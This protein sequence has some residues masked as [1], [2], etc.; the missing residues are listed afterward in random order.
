MPSAFLR[1]PS[2]ELTGITPAAKIR[3]P[4]GKTLQEDVDQ[5]D[6][7]SNYQRSRL[8]GHGLVARPDGELQSPSFNRDITGQEGP[9]M[10]ADESMEG[11]STFPV[12]D[13]EREPEP[14]SE[15]E[16][17][18]SVHKMVWD[19]IEY[20]DQ[21]LSPLRALATKYY[22]GEPFGNEE[23]G[24]SQVV[25][26][27][28][29]DTVLMMMPSLMRIFFGADRALE[30]IPTNKAQ[31]E[32]TDQVTEFVWDVIVNQD[33]EGY[34]AFYEWFKDAL[35]KKLGILKVWYD[36]T[37]ETRAFEANFLSPESVAKLHAEKGVRID[38][39]ELSVANQ[40][41][42]P[43]Y[44]VE[45]TQ[46]KQ[47]GAI[48]F[49]ALPPEEYLFT[50]GSRT[51][52][53]AR[54]RP[55][56]ALFV[57]HRTEMTRSQ[58][59]E[60]GIDEETIE[61]WAFK[62]D[63]LDHNQEEIARQEIV[64]PDTNAIGP[65]ATQKSLYIE[66]YPYLDLDGD[67][68][69]ELCKVVM[70][71]P[72]YH[73][74]SAEPTSHRPFCVICPDPEPHTIVGQG[75]SDWTMDLQ[76]IQSMIL[77]SI[78]DSLALTINPR[79]GFVEGGASLEDI[80][81]PE[82]GAPIRMSMP[83]ALQPIEHSFVG[84]EGLAV[85]E[86]INELKELRSGTT[87]ASAGL[88]ADALQ[89]TTKAAASAAIT[90][91]QAHIEMIARTFAETGVK[92][93]FRMVLELLVSHPPRE[94]MVKMRGRY[95]EM[96][97]SRWDA[98]LDVKVKVAIGAGLDED[99][100]QAL[101]ET[102]EEMKSMFQMWG[103]SNPI[104]TP[105]QYRDINVRMLKLRG[106]MDAENFFQETD[107]N[108]QPPPPPQ[109]DPN[110]V[111][112]E[113]EKAKAET[114]AQAALHKAQMEE[115]KHQ[116]ILQDKIRE[117]ELKIQQTQVDAQLEREKVAIQ[118]QTQIAVAQINAQMEEQRQSLDETMRKLQIMLD[119]VAKVHKS[120]IDAEAKIVA[121]ESAPTPK[122]D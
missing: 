109:Q 38:A 3:R 110:M 24:R 81:N 76:K 80:L 17:Q 89:S 78:L 53:S 10:V 101:L 55:G 117:L 9:E 72:S 87:K 13:G 82:L 74:I 96:D 46:T 99:K 49:I 62:D 71:G 58:L 63:S 102:R 69:A 41:G 104:V 25:D 31:V 30:Y 4:R 60:L 50:R 86:V 42:M 29:R 67:G 23:E 57:G 19:S 64:K 66:G 8:S 88:D 48:R 37:E 39:I 28:L 111:I 33:N 16:I 85:R 59:T 106:Q 15:M 47:D 11:G 54:H 51:V 75:V 121:A 43:L 68:V 90:S 44:R 118:A 56:V 1:S 77:R 20:V 83:N 52:S 34:L 70:L 103:P 35:V 97:P 21:E 84:R 14:M 98:G 73:V 113:A 94:R 108:W 100:F 112:A 92:Q 91:A 105:R 5:D 61:K 22:Q 116:M 119:H 7:R 114:Q 115:Q 12:S 2:D 40:P 27:V 79:L 122:E 65:V 32:Y 6:G 107:P 18:S 93:L 36:D 95:I 26:T 45:Y 120:E